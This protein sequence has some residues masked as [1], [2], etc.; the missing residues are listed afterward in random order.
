MFHRFGVGF[1]IEVRAKGDRGEGGMSLREEVG[2][3][4]GRWMDV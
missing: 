4:V 3:K 2:E 1:V